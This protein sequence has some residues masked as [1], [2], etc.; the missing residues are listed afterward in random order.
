M[1][2]SLFLCGRFLLFLWCV[3]SSSLSR[4]RAFP[5]PP[6]SL[7]DARLRVREGVGPLWLLVFCF[8]CGSLEEEI[9]PLAFIYPLQEHVVDRFFIMPF[10]RFP[11]RVCPR[12]YHGSHQT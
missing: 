12:W 11:S 10:C 8:R 4:A 9:D 7:E 1:W 5:P 3:L 2:G 6:H